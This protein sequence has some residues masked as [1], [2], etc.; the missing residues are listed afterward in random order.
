MHY[1]VANKDKGIDSKVS[2]NLGSYSKGL[3]R[4]LF[5]EGFRRTVV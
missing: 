5:T 2:M 3:F 1:T 4:N